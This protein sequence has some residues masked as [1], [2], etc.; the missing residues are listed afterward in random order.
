MKTKTKV[1]DLTR[2]GLRPSE[3]TF[4][5]TYIYIYICIYVYIYIDS[6]LVALISGYLVAGV[7]VSGVLASGSFRD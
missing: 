5:N 1:M 2:F 7:L 4:V 6:S 3:Y